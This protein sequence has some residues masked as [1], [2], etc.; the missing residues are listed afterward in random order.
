[1]LFNQLK[2][3]LLFLIFPCCILAAP[4]ELSKTGLYDDIIQK[5]LNPNIRFFS[6][7][8]PLWTDGALKM[9][10]IQLPEGSKI[11]TAKGDNW[12]FPNGTKLWKEFSFKGPDGIIRRIET[13]LMEKLQDGTWNFSTYLWNEE[14]TDATLVPESG[15]PNYY[16]INQE[17]TYDIPPKTACIFCHQQKGFDPV[18]GFSALQI[19][20]VRDPDAIHGTPLPLDMTTLE[21]LQANDLVTHH[22]SKWPQIA[23][24]KEN[25]LQKRIFGYFYGNCASCHNPQGSIPM[26]NLKNEEAILEDTIGKLTRFYKI[27]NMQDGET[28]YIKPGNLDASAILYRMKATDSHRM[29]VIGTKIVDELAVEILEDYIKNF[30]SVN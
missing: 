20:P 13:R 22:V 25:P 2:I 3:L 6:P 1:M 24:S 5:S 27:P 23:E 8:Y 7:Q 10:W 15:V 19:S 18:L 4:S 9:R 17:V 26:F 11:N 28:F 14:E 12:I 16:Q 21:E 30:I 29:P